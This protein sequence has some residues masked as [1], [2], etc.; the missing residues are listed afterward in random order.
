MQSALELVCDRLPLVSARATHLFETDEE[1][2]ELCSEYKM[3][4]ETANR[5]ENDPRS[6]VA[7]RHEYAALR[8][9]IEGEL[10][11]Y[12]SEHLDA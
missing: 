6:N 7:L 9:R 12:L 4:T 5:M 11:R 1:F 10:L 2:R 8:L 3:C